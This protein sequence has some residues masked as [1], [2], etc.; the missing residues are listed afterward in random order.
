MNFVKNRENEDKIVN[1]VFKKNHQKSEYCPEDNENECE[2]HQE[3]A[4]IVKK[5]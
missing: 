2:Y 5:S 3:I 1:F 4:N